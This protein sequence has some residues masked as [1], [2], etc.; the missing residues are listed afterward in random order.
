[1]KKGAMMQNRALIPRERFISSRS[2]QGGMNAAILVAI[3]AGLIILY[4]IFLPATEREKIINEKEQIAAPDE[5]SSNML[6]QASP[7]LLSSTAGLENDNGIPN[8]FLVETTNAKELEKI[9]PFIVRNGWFDKKTKKIDFDI[10]DIDNTDNVVLSFTTK[11]RQGIL[12]IKLNN[13]VVFENEI[14]SETIEP[15]SLSKKLLGKTNSLEFSVSSVGAKFWTT[16]EYSLENVKIIGDITDV[17]KQEGIN[18]FAISDSEFASMDKAA[19]KFIPYCGNVNELGTLD[20][21]INN[22]KVFSA[23][24]VCDNAYKQT[25]PKSVL[26]EGE[27]NIVFRTNRGSYSV[28]QIKISLDFKE[29]TVKTYFFEVNQSIFKKIRDGE[30]DVQLTIKFVE[31][32]K[33]KR[34]KLDINGRLETVETDKATFS[35]IINNRIVEGNNFVRLEPLQDDLGIAE[36]RI[37][38]T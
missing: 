8:I 21:F 20:I 13:E 35:K 34:A 4:I 16:N 22:K 11:K 2:A 3:I 15:V 6:L 33:Q 27:N 37:E 36:L 12:A 28:E 32:K 10:G 23:V 25:I 1:M 18:I 38:L 5:A 14:T 9:N 29:P 19:L 24:P 26:N 7:G 17:S 30:K 31:D